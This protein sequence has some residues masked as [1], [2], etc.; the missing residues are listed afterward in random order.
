MP[1]V[2]LAEMRA[3]IEVEREWRERELRLLRNH[4]AYLADEDD[5]R[6]ARKALI[7]MLY[8]HFEGVCK[9]LLIIYVN[10]INLLKLRVSS[11]TPSLGAASCTEIFQELRNPNSKCKIFGR[12]LPDNSA[13]H[14]FARDREFIEKA[15]KFAEQEVSINVDVVVDTES[16][17]KPVVLKKILY[18]LGLEPQ[19]SE[20]WDATIHQLL[21]R[22]N[23]VAHGSARAGLSDSEYSKLDQAVGLV[24]DE[25]VKAVS[26]AVSEK[27]YMAQESA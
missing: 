19:L 15:W 25:L 16:N 5:R 9:A 12:Q 14:R 27:Q 23:D 1:G 7:V 17:L 6:I 18:Q 21:R 2:D 20:P 22:R 8:A 4:V 3:E 11:V 13:L 24:I 26:R 10:R